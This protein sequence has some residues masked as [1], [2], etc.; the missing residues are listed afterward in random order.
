[1]VHGPRRDDLALDLDPAGQRGGVGGGLR[2]A[3]V[4]GGEA[5]LEHHQPEREAQQK[6]DEQQRDDLAAL[7]AKRPLHAKHARGAQPQLRPQPVTALI[8]FSNALTI[9]SPMLG[10]V[11][12]S[13]PATATS[14]AITA[15]HS[16]VLCPLCP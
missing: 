15:S 12:M 16:I 14:I 13:T 11:A 9:V 3:L 5:D 10:T 2:A 4:V 8:S 1:V 7:V 6:D